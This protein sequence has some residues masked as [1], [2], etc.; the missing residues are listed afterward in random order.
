MFLQ[1]RFVSVRYTELLV[2]VRH[3]K[4]NQ[5]WRP[6]ATLEPMLG[7]RRGVRLGEPAKAPTPASRHKPLVT[8]VPCLVV[9]LFWKA[10]ICLLANMEFFQLCM[11]TNEYEKRF[12]SLLIL[13]CVELKF[14]GGTLVVLWDRVCYPHRASCLSLLC[15]CRQRTPKF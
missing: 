7:R 3:C 4:G 8:R 15:F 9:R 6:N 5:T 2:A 10:Q 12:S 11:R 14:Q 1:G 13:Y